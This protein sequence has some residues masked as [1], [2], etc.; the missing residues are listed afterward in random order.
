MLKFNLYVL[1]KRHII[2]IIVGRRNKSFLNSN[3]YFEFKT[4]RMVWFLKIRK[5]EK[6]ILCYFITQIIHIK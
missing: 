2:I 4:K 5:V 1:I 3:N 6:L